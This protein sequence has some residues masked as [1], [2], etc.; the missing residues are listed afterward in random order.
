M[1]PTIPSSRL[2]SLSQSLT[3][4][5]AVLVPVDAGVAFPFE[6]NASD[7]MHALC[8]SPF[9][10]GVIARAVARLA[11]GSESV[12]E[13]L[14][15]MLVIPVHLPRLLVGGR[16][17]AAERLE[18]AEARAAPAALER[19]RVVGVAGQPRWEGGG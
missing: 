14:A 16:F 17:V 4:A 1:S 19:R 10:R 11:V 13:P 2:A 15:G 9:A 12:V 7:M 6:H 18:G 3:E 5:G 8:T